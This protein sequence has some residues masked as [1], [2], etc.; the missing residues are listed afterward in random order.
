MAGK[1][2][3]DMFING[4]LRCNSFIA[5]NNSIGNSGFDATDKLLAIKQEHQ[6]SKTYSQ[7]HGVAGVNERR[8]IHVA[9]GGGTVYAVWA[10]AAVACT[11]TATITFTLL[12][13]GTNILSSTLQLTS[14]TA[15]FVKVIGTLGAGATYVAGDFFEVQVAV[16]AGAGAIGQGAT[17]QI[18]F[19]EN[20]EG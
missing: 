8:P 18:V 14:A 17:L 5:P 9:F 2:D 16:A 1:I 20:F 6:H 13:N 10:A 7:V 4:E 11:S 3:G 19:R 15:A 12:K